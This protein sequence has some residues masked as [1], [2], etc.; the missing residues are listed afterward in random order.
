MPQMLAAPIGYQGISLWIPFF[1]LL[2]D[3]LLLSTFGSETFFGFI[4]G[5][6]LLELAVALA[7]AGFFAASAL[8]LDSSAAA[9]SV[10]V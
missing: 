10:A 4:E 8:V 1:F 5:A 9:T 7:G 3:S 6:D 2:V